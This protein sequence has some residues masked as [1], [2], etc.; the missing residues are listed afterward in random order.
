MG[1]FRREMKQTLF[2]EIGETKIRQSIERFYEKAFIDP[3]ISHFFFQ[4]DHDHLSKMQFLFTATM[5]GSRSHAYTGTSMRS[6][7]GC[8]NIKKAHFDRRRTLLIETLKEVGVDKKHI[9][10]WV[11][12]EEN[13]RDLVV[14]KV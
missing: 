11:A 3:I 1:A 12:L 2:E 13:F 6:A 10:R 7:H 14:G 5:L 9:D 4:K 8:L